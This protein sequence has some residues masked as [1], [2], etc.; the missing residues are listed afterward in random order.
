VTGDVVVTFAAFDPASESADLL[1]AAGLT[2]RHEPLTGPRPPG[3]LTRL[4]RGAVAG[5]VS[6]DL[7][8]RAFFGTCPTLRVLARVGVGVDTI[9]L[10]AATEA[11]VVVT[12]T[13]GANTV[14]VAEHAIA[15]VLAVARNI[16][17]G[18]ASVRSGAW[19]RRRDLV[20]PDL[21]GSTI[22]I[23][24]GG[25]I[26][27]AVAKRLQAFDVDLLVADVLPVDVDGATQVTIDS[28]LEHSDVVTIHVPLFDATQHLIGEREL[29][30]MK[31]GAILVNTSRG[32]IVD[33]SALAAAL[34]SGHLRGAGIDVFSAEPPYDSPLL[35]LT[36]VVLSPHVAGLSSG[37]IQAMLRGA[38]L[39][40]IAVLDG[41][42]PDGVVNR[43]A[44]G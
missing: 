25:A 12:T 7:F 38:A 23:V 11:G 29:S 14:S 8:D 39:S 35:Q 32:G 1:R 9:D 6:T 3:E 28:L 40:V 18:D 37:A 43:D 4:M 17:N 10:Q 27:R 20:G 21:S 24:G 31:P 30:L 44:L 26:G 34:R 22:G 5:V 42:I 36:N 41:R 19:H 15:L 2:P 13:P 16:P 33:E